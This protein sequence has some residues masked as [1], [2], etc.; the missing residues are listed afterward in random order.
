MAKGFVLLPR[1]GVAKRILAWLTNR[2]ANWRTT[3][4]SGNVPPYAVM[5]HTRRRRR[6]FG[7]ML[8]RAVAV[9][10]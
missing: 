9:H 5:A 10:K 7:T 8:G 6:R 2:T 4:A 3:S 1:R